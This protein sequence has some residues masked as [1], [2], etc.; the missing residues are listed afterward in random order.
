M[1]LISR[2]AYTV[3]FGFGGGS[4][5]KGIVYVKI[6]KVPYLFHHVGVVFL[7]HVVD[8]GPVTDTENRMRGC[9]TRCTSILDILLLIKRRHIYICVCL[10]GLGVDTTFK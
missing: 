9:V 6:V 7:G 2:P 3:S 4:N 10:S 8:E 5:N 1:K